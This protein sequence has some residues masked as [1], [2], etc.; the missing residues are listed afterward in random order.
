MVLLYLK[1]QV[2]QMTHYCLIRLVTR[3]PCINDRPLPPPSCLTHPLRL[4][5]DKKERGMP[6]KSN[7]R[8]L[9]QTQQ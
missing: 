9:S 5:I 7:I 8:P 6:K 3:P 4:V 2:M 1:Y